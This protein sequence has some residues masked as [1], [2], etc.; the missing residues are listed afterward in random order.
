MH[1]KMRLIVVPELRAY[2]DQLSKRKRHEIERE[3]RANGLPL[4][5]KSEEI[6][7]LVAVQEF[8]VAKVVRASLSRE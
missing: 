3:C 7:Q 2:R 8:K 6:S 4:G 1:H 5:S